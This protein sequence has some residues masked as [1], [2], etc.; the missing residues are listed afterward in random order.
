MTTTIFILLLRVHRDDVGHQA[1]LA[2]KD[3]LYVACNLVGL[4]DILLC[5]VMFSYVMLLCYVIL[6]SDL[7]CLL[8]GV[9]LLCCVM[10]CYVALRYVM[11][12][13]VMLYYV[14]LCCYVVLCYVMLCYVM[15]CYKYILFWTSSY[16]P[17]FFLEGLLR[18]IPFSISVQSIQFI[19]VKDT[20]YNII[21][22]LAYHNVYC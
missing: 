2:L 19:S 14:M 20:I 4:L 17:C 10:L 3:Q 16:L 11:L 9:L 13:Y 12:Y 1:P 22:Y 6:C 7:L 21:L 5:H 15:L 8:C 18:T